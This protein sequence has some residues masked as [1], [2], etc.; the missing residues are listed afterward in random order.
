MGLK[1][2]HAG[3]ETCFGWD[4]RHPR[5][6]DQNTS[7]IQMPRHYD[8]VSCVFDWRDRGTL[9]LLVLRLQPFRHDGKARDVCE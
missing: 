5:C 8:F 4:P 2:L 1:L 3:F 9:L 6:W 7:R